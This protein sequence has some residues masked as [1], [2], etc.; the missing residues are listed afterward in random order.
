MIITRYPVVRGI[1]THLNQMDDMIDWLGYLISP[2]Y[3]V[4]LLVARHGLSSTD[5]KAR[6]KTIIPH[7]SAAISLITQSLGGPD[8]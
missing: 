5:A 8:L 6:T 4:D 1:S 7:V 2:E 3:L